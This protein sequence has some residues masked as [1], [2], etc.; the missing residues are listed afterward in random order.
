ML[1]PA[2]RGIP[3]SHELVHVV[4]APD[5]CVQAFGASANFL[6]GARSIGCR[7]KV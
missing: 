3:Q 1:M 5:P 4:S 7:Y 2:L 6:D